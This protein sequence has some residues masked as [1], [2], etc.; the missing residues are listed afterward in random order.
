MP[1]VISSPDSTDDY[2]GS[3]T[4][5][6]ARNTD[7]PPALLYR[8][9]QGRELVEYRQLQARYQE[10]LQEHVDEARETLE[11]A[12]ADDESPESLAR[13]AIQEN[14][15]LELADEAL[16][17]EAFE[18]WMTGDLE[19]PDAEYVTTQQAVRMLLTQNFY[20][21]LELRDEYLDWCVGVTVGVDNIE[22][23]DEDGN[24][25]E[26][27]WSSDGQVRRHTLTADERDD[28]TTAH[29]GRR[30]I[31][32]GFG[33]KDWERERAPFLYARTVEQREGLSADQKKD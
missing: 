20:A 1:Y 18:D 13:R 31:I 19:D 16:D 32:D 22:I 2:D 17:D 7:T 3:Y 9:P 33:V 4:F 12:L 21:D 30:R 28:G 29:E 15:G 5:P 23:R 24:R 11:A 14:D 26:L 6:S 10:A 25:R 27:D 8:T